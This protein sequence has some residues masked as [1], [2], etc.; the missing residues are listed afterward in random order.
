VN[1]DFPY[2]F[3]ASDRQAAK[4]HADFPLTQEYLE[5]L[6]RIAKLAYA[7]YNDVVSQCSSS[8]AEELWEALDEVNFLHE[9]P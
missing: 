3:Y 4:A 2:T 9:S 6:E 1:N 7:F 5:R 8:C